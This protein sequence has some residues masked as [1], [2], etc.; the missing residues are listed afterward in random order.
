[1]TLGLI[2]RDQW[3]GGRGPVPLSATADPALPEHMSHIDQL[4]MAPQAHDVVR[5]SCGRTITIGRL[6]LT[7]PAHPLGRIT[8]NIDCQPHDHEQVWMSLTAAE[9][10]RLAGSLLDQADAA[11]KEY[12]A[13]TDGAP[14]AP[15]A[16]AVRPVLAPGQIEVSFVSGELYAVHM[17]GHHMLTDQPVKDGGRDV[18][19][20]P[21]ELLVASL[22]SCVAFYSGRYLSRHDI[23]RA[24]LQ[25]SGRFELTG[26]PARVGVIRLRIRVP[27]EFPAERAAALLAV[28]SHCT[29]HNTLRTPPAVDIALASP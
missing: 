18:A 6:T 27:A 19:A 23:S 28:A 21:T 4:G 20:T 8:V 13:E 16:S 25:V 3:S 14:T 29:V 5:T 26:G 1:M 2:R 9:C 24:G 22:A 7:G 11:D 15:A 10:R 12:A 17:R